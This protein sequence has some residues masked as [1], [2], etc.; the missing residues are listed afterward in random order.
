M[1]QQQCLSCRG[2]G[3]GTFGGPCNNC[4]GR[5]QVGNAMALMQALVVIAVVVFVV[6]FVV[7][8]H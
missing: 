4:R 3:R 1:T 5:G 7:I 6:Y 8:Q 2:T